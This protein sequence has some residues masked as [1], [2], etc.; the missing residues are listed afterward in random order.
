MQNGK[1]VKIL[2]R[3]NYNL[4]DIVNRLFQARLTE[5]TKMHLVE[6]K[7]YIYLHNH[8][9][10]SSSDSDGHTSPLI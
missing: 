10:E 2:D 7:N 6:Y 5:E 3:N 8:S 1:N 4:E 9:S